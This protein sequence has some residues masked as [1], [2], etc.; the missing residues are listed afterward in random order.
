MK[1]VC[2]IN[3]CVGCMACV[4]SCTK[5]AIEIRDSLKAYNAVINEK[6]C[7]NCNTCHAVCPQ[8]NP[9]KK[10]KPI[11]WGQGWTK[12]SKIRSRSS[13]GGFAAAISIAF[14][15]SG[16][17]VCSCVFHNGE[18]VFEII[19]DLREVTKF[20]GSRY[21]KSNPKGIFKEVRYY[22]KNRKKVLFIGLPCQVAAMKNYIK[23]PLLQ[24]L[25]TIDL[26]CHGTPSPQLLEMFL[27][28]YGLKLKD[29]E[30]IQFRTKNSFKLKD[31]YKSIVTKG[32]RNRYLIAFLNGLIYTDNCYECEHARIERGS[33]ITLGDSWGS[34]LSKKEQKKGISLVLCQSEKGQYLLEMSDLYIEFVDL[35]I[36][37]AHN[38]Q[39]NEPSAL[40]PGRA[41]FF[42]G[43]ASGKS[44]NALVRKIVPKQCIKQDI[45]AF[46]IK[47]KIISGEGGYTMIYHKKSFG[48]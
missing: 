26:I 17:Y 25:Y 36:A 9:I 28:Q 3:R 19:N 12:D 6:N 11:F 7:V 34:Q 30:D 16:G 4:D 44:F 1:T 15:K 40:I 46:L 24:Y 38:H 48:K 10:M 43:C 8:N 32:V 29:M 20:M 5:N 33:D 27:A 35:E 2:E 42:D 18:F 21:V 22:L 37:I 47:T 14:I 41:E 39:L 13:S 45:K 31:Y 23:E